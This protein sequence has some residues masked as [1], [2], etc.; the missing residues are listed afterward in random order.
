MSLQAC[1][2]SIISRQE[3]ERRSKFSPPSGA[4]CLRVA[5][6]S[7]CLHN[8]RSKYLSIL[9]M[10]EEDHLRR[11]ELRRPRQRAEKRDSDGAGPVPEAT[12]S[13]CA[14]GVTHPGAAVL[15]QPAP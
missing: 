3:L 5:D 1:R 8:D 9:G 13:I 11:E 14:R 12:F 10:G 6:T 15:Q 4:D 2:R 7:T